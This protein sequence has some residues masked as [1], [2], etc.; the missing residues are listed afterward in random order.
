MSGTLLLAVADRIADAALAAAA[1]RGFPPMTVV[2]L[3][4]GGHPLVVKRDERSAIGRFEIAMGKAHGCLAMGFGGRELARRADAMPKFFISIAQ[5][6]PHGIVPVAGGVLIRD[7]KGTLL[8]SMGISG[9]T[10]DE[11]DICAIAGV[12]SMDLVADTGDPK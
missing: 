1:E 3:D 12:A 7:E 11:D 8:G 10:S 4:P 5:L 6:L 9:G 2:V